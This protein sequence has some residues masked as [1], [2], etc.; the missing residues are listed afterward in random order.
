MVFHQLHAAGALY[1]GKLKNARNQERRCEGSCCFEGTLP[2]SLSAPSEAV[3]CP[4]RTSDEAEASLGASSWGMR[5]A[6]V[7]MAHMIETQHP[8]IIHSLDGADRWGRCPLC[9]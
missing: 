4:S 1:C 6:M 8:H 9:R 7:M 2:L 3:T 5:W